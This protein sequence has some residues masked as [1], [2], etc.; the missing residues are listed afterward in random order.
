MKNV[1][2]EIEEQDNDALNESFNLKMDL[3]DSYKGKTQKM[4]K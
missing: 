4:K 1:V 3:S 2:N